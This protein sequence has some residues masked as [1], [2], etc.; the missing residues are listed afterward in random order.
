MQ[1]SVRKSR[2]VISGCAMRSGLLQRLLGSL[3]LVVPTLGCTSDREA[4]S[5]GAVGERATAAIDRPAQPPH[6]RSVLLISLDT[7][8]PDHLGAYGYDRPTSP[9]IDSLAREGVVFLDASSTSPWTLPAHA[10]M[11][12]GLYPDRHGA[13]TFQ[14]A[15]EASL[16]TLATQL[17]RKGFQTAAVVNSLH[18]TERFGLARGFER[19]LYVEESEDRVSPSTWVTDQAI[20]WLKELRGK[21]VFL[22]VHYYDVHSSY[23]ALPRFTRLFASDYDGPVDGSSEQLV[24]FKLSPEFVASCQSNPEQERCH[25]WVKDPL[26]E[27]SE[28]VEIDEAGARHLID[29]Y[30]AGIRQTDEELGR[31]I[32]FLRSERLIDQ[33]LVILTSD[34]G[35]QFLEHGSVLHSD[36]QYQELLGV[37]LILRGP[38]IPRNVRIEAPVSLVDL[39]PTVLAVLGLTGGTEASDGLDLSPLWQKPAST[40][41]SGEVFRDRY[42]FAEASAA[43]LRLAVRHGGYKLI[44]DRATGEDELYDLAADPREQTDI[45]DDQPEIAQRLRERL[46]RRAEHGAEGARV[47]LSPEE[48]EH[49][50]ALG[51]L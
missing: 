32:G 39:V 20:E 30:D 5:D 38:G 4:A 11:L 17:G 2:A 1:P 36:D 48:T 29:L 24:S 14:Q 16:P 25:T 19:F 45:S 35:E 18:L 33:F 51:Y 10:S 43:N 6:P 9:V 49:L 27:T 34:H 37:P 21:R 26:D 41:T 7:L 47:E 46:L 15:M 13:K 8:R 40:A 44:Y 28:R 31:L 12:S 50:R 3:L 23:A 22:F 42:L